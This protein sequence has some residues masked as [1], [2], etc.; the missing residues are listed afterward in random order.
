MVTFEIDIEYDAEPDRV[1][2]AFWDLEDWPAVAPHV[3]AIEMLYG[4]DQA[5]ILIMHVATKKKLDA[6]KSVR[7]KQRNTIFYFQPA[8]PTILRTHYGSWR[9]VATTDGTTV[10][11]QHTVDINTDAARSFLGDAEAQVQDADDV[12]QQIINL[13]RNNSLQTMMAL[14][15][16]LEQTN[17]GTYA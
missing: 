6:F 14:K 3:R 1:L 16:R 4:D 8:P 17:G 10:I 15:K 13:I 11:S 7:I 9:F 12:Q 5:Q 2:A